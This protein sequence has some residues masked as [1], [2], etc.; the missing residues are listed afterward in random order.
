MF[1][2]D[3]LS[4]A[5]RR[6]RASRLLDAI[7]RW[8][9]H[10]SPV[11]GCRQGRRFGWKGRADNKWY[12]GLHKF[13]LKQH[14]R[15]RLPDP[16]RG[17]T[18]PL[19]TAHIDCVSTEARRRRGQL[20]RGLRGGKTVDRQV[21][22]FIQSLHRRPD[23]WVFLEALPSAWPAPLRATVARMDVRSRAVL[24]EFRER[25]FMPLSGQ[26]TCGVRAML[27]SGKLQRIG[28]AADVVCMASTGEVVVIELKIDSV[29]WFT[30]RQY[31]LPPYESIVDTWFARHQLQLA[32]TQ[33]L[34]EKSQFFKALGKA[35]GTA[36]QY[37]SELWRVAFDVDVY[38]L[39]DRIVSRLLV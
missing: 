14:I 5:A 9:A 8:D 16:T 17:G 39:D 38:P 19:L 23:P 7:R 3:H 30:A 27:P 1:T 35:T 24:R 10:D 20:T 29:P 13:I 34:L 22:L 6:C 11:E 4:S 15:N 21:N 25:G 36:C 18:R 33:R 32:Y 26:I 12:K 31:L 37:T 28:T 2:G